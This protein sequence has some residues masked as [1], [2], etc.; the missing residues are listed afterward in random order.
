MTPETAEK[1]LIKDYLDAKGIFNFP[2]MQGV[3]SYKGL[4]DRFAIKNGV[5]YALEIKSSKG[6]QSEAQREFQ[7]LWEANGGVY[8]LGG[9]DEILKKIK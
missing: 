2:I 8:I 9:I 1:H 5:C 3:A 7:E 6:Y 4:P